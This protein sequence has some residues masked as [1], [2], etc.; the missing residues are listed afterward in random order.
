MAWVATT[1][2]LAATL[3]SCGKQAD[4]T[5]E[6]AA[7]EVKDKAVGDAKAVEA[8][9]KEKEAQETAIDA[10]VYAYRSRYAAGHPRSLPD[11]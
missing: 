5:A 8:A 1:V 4:T 10:Y 6:R 11:M 3:A 2:F 9:A 7:T